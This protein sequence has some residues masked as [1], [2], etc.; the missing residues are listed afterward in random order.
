MGSRHLKLLVDPD[1]MLL[2]WD[3][4]VLNAIEVIRIVR[5]PGVFLR[6]NLPVINAHHACATLVR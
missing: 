1:V 4:P 6:P 5:S 2:D 3:M